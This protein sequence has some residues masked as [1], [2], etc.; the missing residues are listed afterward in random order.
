MISET[1][2]IKIALAVAAI[3]L[4]SLLFISL[5]YAPK[6]VSISKME[7]DEGNQVSITGLVTKVSSGQKATTFTLS[8]TDSTTIVLF[9][10]GSVS[11]NSKVR[12]IG[13]VVDGQLIADRIIEL[14]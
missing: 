8:Q 9:G 14:R 11:E 4:I 13:R 6:E 1:H 7:F 2:L 12:V 3:G 5:N 10:N